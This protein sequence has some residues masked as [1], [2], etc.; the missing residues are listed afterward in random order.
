MRGCS[1]QAHLSAQE[2]APSTGPR[3]S[4]PY[5][6]RG[7][8]QSP[9]TTSSEGPYPSYRLENVR[10]R[11]R[12]LRRRVDFDRVFQ[13]GR[14]NGGRLMSVRCVPNQAGVSRYGFV[15]S[16]RVGKAV[17]RNRVKR[18]LREALRLL[19][20]REGYDV[21]IS[22]RPEAATQSFHTLRKELVLLLGRAR[23]LEGR[24]T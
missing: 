5:G 2:A 7:R 14:H 15:I 6:D 23:L 22:A 13:H 18:R 21:V 8:A 16:R 24:V 4:R 11:D 3:V 19:P 10:P 12:R 1:A 17:V 9:A 20:V